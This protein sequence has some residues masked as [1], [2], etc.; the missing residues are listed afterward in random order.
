MRWLALCLAP[1][2][3][4]CAWRMYAPRSAAAAARTT[5]RDEKSRAQA[6][7]RGA[8]PSSVACRALA[9]HRRPPGAKLRGVLFPN[10]RPRV[11]PV[12]RPCLIIAKD[13]V[14]KCHV[15][16]RFVEQAKFW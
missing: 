3:T 1:N 7:Y 12:P 2:A 4:L 13:F 10:D 6:C 8:G 14:E 5:T 16:L 9:S 11:L 15:L